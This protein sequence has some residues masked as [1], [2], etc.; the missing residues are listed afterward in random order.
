MIRHQLAQTRAAALLLALTGL[1][2]A[3]SDSDD[4]DFEMDASDV[5]AEDGGADAA[6]KN[7]AR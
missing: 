3:C 7:D 5:E 4:V 2:S 1:S 6:A